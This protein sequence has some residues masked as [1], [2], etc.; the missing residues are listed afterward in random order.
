MHLQ[1]AMPYQ[2]CVS[3]GPAGEPEENLAES[4]RSAPAGEAQNKARLK[5]VSQDQNFWG[6]DHSSPPPRTPMKTRDGN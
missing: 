5:P 6:G 4:Y 2:V 1:Q 3:A